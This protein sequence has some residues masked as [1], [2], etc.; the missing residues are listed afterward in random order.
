M[1]LTELRYIVALAE[2]RHFSRAAE[3]CFVSQ[4]TLS[5]AVRKLEDELG[6]ALFERNRNEIAPTAIGARIIAQARI[7]LEESQVVMQLAREGKNPLLGPLRLGAIYTIGPYLL[8]RLI[9]PLTR[10]A[11]EM[12]L[13]IEEN[14]TA[15]LAERLRQGALDIVILS[16]P[17]HHPQIRTWALYDEPFVVITPPLHPWRERDAIGAQDLAGEDVLLLGEG[18]CF[19]NQVIEACPDCIQDNG[20]DHRLRGFEGTSLETLRQMVASGLGV[21]VLPLT[22]ALS[23]PLTESL[24]RVKPFQGQPPQRR[25]ALAWRRSFTRQAAIDILRQAIRNAEL[26]GVTYLDESIGPA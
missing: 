8:P 5:V 13:M 7:V 10:L 11:P 17:F 9:G 1:T 4:P 24:L 21:S 26:P 19:R 20:Q 3:R 2:E 14:Y 12:P 15:V 23:S 25:V 6:V 22:A 16:L 18:H